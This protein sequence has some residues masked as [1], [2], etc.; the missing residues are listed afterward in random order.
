ME[1]MLEEFFVKKLPPLSPAAKDTTAR[2][3]PWIIIIFGGLG[4]LMW[5]SS[6]K[7]IIGFSG[8]YGFEGPGIFDMVSLAITPVIE[9]IVIYGGY[10]M[11]NKR[12]RGW[13]V[14]LYMVIFGFIMNVLYFNIVGVVLN[15]L[16]SYLLFQT[17]G[18]FNR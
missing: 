9:I 3:L 16:F 8:L 4:L 18:Y 6:L 7:F 15:F 10:L 1:Q 14:A 17:K 13:R 5:V 2:V 11:L 12:Q